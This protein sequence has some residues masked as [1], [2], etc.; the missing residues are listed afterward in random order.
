MPTN[1]EV[2]SLLYELKEAKFT[3]TS[4]ATDEHINLVKYMY[5]KNL[6]GKTANSTYRLSDNGQYIIDKSLTYETWLMLSNTKDQWVDYI[7]KTLV[8]E[9]KSQF[10]LI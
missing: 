9:E 3:V 5:G 8:K 4:R 6:L 1:S 2:T 10:F 7:I